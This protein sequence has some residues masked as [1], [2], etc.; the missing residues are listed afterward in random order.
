MSGEQM[1]GEGRRRNPRTCGE[2]GAV[3]VASRRH[4]RWCSDRCR[5]RAWRHRQR[6]GEERAGSNDVGPLEKQVALLQAALARIQPDDPCA[7][8]GC[9]LTSDEYIARARAHAEAPG[10]AVPWRSEEWDHPA[11]KTLRATVTG[12]ANELDR[13]RE[14]NALLRGW[15]TDRL[16]ISETGE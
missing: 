4:A 10:R 15:V 11:V 8:Q 1:V 7:E 13:L 2:C 6:S 12:H 3:F 14:E 5:L 16:N 9:R